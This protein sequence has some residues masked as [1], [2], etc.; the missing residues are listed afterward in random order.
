M[1]TSE[2][3]VM[4]SVD[5]DA[6]PATSSTAVDHRGGLQVR[7]AKRYEQ[8][9]V[10]ACSRI[11]DA[12]IDGLQHAGEEAGAV[13]VTD[14]NPT[15]GEMLEAIVAKKLSF[16]QLPIFYFGVAADQDTV[17]QIMAVRIDRLAHQVS[18]HT[19]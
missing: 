12:T 1:E 5:P 16:H 13:L 14:L 6:L 3:V 11:L 7:G 17:E 4:D 8:L 10:A 19:V 2:M 15:N 9:G 18:R